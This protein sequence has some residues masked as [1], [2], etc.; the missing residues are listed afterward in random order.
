[1][2]ITTDKQVDVL[3]AQ[4]QGVVKAYKKYNDYVNRNTKSTE[5]HHVIFANNVTIRNAYR[6][7]EHALRIQLQCYGVIYD[8]KGKYNIPVIYKENKNEEKKNSSDNN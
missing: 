4:H 7:L 1:M 2:E 3:I 6:N 5:D 8:G